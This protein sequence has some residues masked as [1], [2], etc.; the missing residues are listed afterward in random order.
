MVCKHIAEA[1]K[2]IDELGKKL[3]STDPSLYEKLGPYVE[4]EMADKQLNF[5]V[6]AADEMTGKAAEFLKTDFIDKYGTLSPFHINSVKAQSLS[7]YVIEIIEILQ[8]CKCLSELKS[9]VVDK[10]YDP[11]LNKHNNL[12]VKYNSSL[13]EHESLQKSFG[14]LKGQYDEVSVNYKQKEWELEL[15]EKEY[16]LAQMQLV[17]LKI[18]SES[19]FSQLVDVRKLL[20][21]KEEKITEMM[22][23]LP[24]K[25]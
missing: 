8:G 5:L 24:E 3:R 12:V 14:E 2:K 7:K 6:R 17:S 25:I 1:L 4:Y 18:Q 10:H 22:L 11:L 16:T 15:K 20:E 23:I 21:D 13:T 9:E 19:Y